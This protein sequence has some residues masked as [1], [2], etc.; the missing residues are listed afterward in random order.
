M[1]SC[2]T[3]ESEDRDRIDYLHKYLGAVGRARRRRHPGPWLLRLVAAGQLRVGLR[4]LQALRL[5]VDYSTLQR[6]PKSSFYWY[7]DLIGAGR[8]LDPEPPSGRRGRG[9][10][11][12]R[13][14]PPGR[15]ASSGLAN[16]PLVWRTHLLLDLLP[17]L[18]QVGHGGDEQLRV[19]MHRVSEDLLGRP[20]LDDAA[21]AQ[22]QGPLADVVA[23]RGRVMKSTPS[24]RAFSSP[25]R[26]RTS[27]RVEAS[28]MLITSSAT[29][30]L[31]SSRSAGDQQPLELAAAELVRV[32]A[33]HGLGLE[34]DGIERG[35]QLAVPIRA[36]DSR[37]VRAAD[38]AEHAVDFEDRVVRVEGV[39]EHALHVAADSPSGRR[40][41]SETSVPSN[42]IEPSVTGVS[43][44][45]I[46]PTVDFPLPLSS[47]R[48][49]TSQAEIEGRRGPRS[50]ASRRT[51]RS[52]GDLRDL[53]E[54]EHQ[55]P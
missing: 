23:E 25:S 9:R 1:S 31:M 27:I 11:G 30:Y 46:F 37:E 29:R 21:A 54:L 42:V 28:S 53:V 43:R 51:C 36:A 34:A 24:P 35:V 48:E 33:E 32:L 40:R 39:L 47:I 45:I 41:S 18:A 55:C 6:V 50:G 44:R 12:G 22:D 14:R 26:L 13:P 52:C 38:H 2:T 4:L 5:Y 49:T 15:S 20:H 16:R 19:R 8:L 3:D 17:F 10:P 7:R